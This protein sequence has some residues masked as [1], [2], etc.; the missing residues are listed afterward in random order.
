MEMEEIVMLSFLLFFLLFCVLLLF[1]G[2]SLFF[3]HFCFPPPFVGAVEK[4]ED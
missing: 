4:K 1:S 3:E 2:S